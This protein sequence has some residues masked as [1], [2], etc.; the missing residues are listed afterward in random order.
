MKN[1]LL[2][3]SLL[4]C[5]QSFS[6]DGEFIIYNNGLIY[7]DTTVK[8]LRLI[9]DS[10]NLKFRI[11]DLHKVYRAKAQA[12]AN[13][14]SLSEGDINAARKDIESN[15]SY[16]DFV[17]KYPSAKIESDLLVVRSMY[18]D[19]QEK[20]ILS[21]SSVELDGSGYQE[22]R[23]TEN[24]SQYSAALNQKWVFR[25]HG[26]TDYSGERVEAF[27]FTTEFSEKPLPEKYARLVQYADCMVDT[28]VEI[29]K[30]SASYG[31]S[32]S[33]RN[34]KS[35]VHEFTVYAD[36]KTEKPEFGGK[37]SKARYEKFEKKL[38]EWNSSKINILHR[39][40]N[41]DNAF[42]S[43]FQEALKEAKEDGYS[44]DNF[45]NYV[46]VLD[47]KKM[48]LELKRSRRVMGT[49]SM[50]NG[51][52]IHAVNIAILSAETINWE[53]FLRSHLDIMNDRFDRVSDG[54]Y[55]WDARKTYIKE[56]EVL[57]INV[58]DLL[59]GISLRIENPGKHHYYGSIGRL[60][61]AISE[62]EQLHRIQKIILD[63]IRD[64]ELD[65]YNRIMMYYLF[66]NCNYY[67]DNKAQQEISL[68]TLKSAVTTLPKY[69][70]EKIKFK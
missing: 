24:L 36:L 49:C 70:S 16:N 35:K 7:A 14:I 13:Y 55:A 20:D 18:K 25:Y 8:Q 26:K 22:L 23:F 41:Y 57:D 40:W 42:R 51:P 34:E 31:S 60:G 45:E 44:N 38:S 15:I 54:S 46:S 9:V 58:P 37:Y 53:V 50:D 3:F 47:S 6:Q 48:V 2:A 64:E 52:R 43:L 65:N 66:L 61:R 69:I 11:C 59:L 68:E 10:L 4:C 19:Y 63:M 56:L 12:K 29:F 27:Y 1:S 28:T 21:I 39:L 30:M 33:S 32:L 5:V 17:S 67:I 62:S